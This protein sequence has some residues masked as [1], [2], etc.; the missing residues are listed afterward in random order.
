MTNL[1]SFRWLTIIVMALTLALPGEA[2]TPDLKGLWRSSSGAYLLISPVTRQNLK[3]EVFGADGS[4]V[5]TYKAS[6]SDSGDRFYYTAAG[7]DNI[8]SREISSQKIKVE[9]SLG[10]WSATWTRP[11]P[12]Q[13][14]ESF[15]H[16][17]NKYQSDRSL[18]LKRTGRLFFHPDLLRRIEE[19]NA[20]G[21][22]EGKWFDFDPFSNGQM[23]AAEIKLGP[24]NKHGGDKVRIPVE[25]SY[26]A[27]GH[28]VHAVNLELGR[29]G[30]AWRVTNLHYPGR[31][32]GQAWDLLTWM[33]AKPAGEIPAPVSEGG[34]EL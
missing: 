8:L 13:V 12:E 6:W 29:H 10:D 16:I 11:S 19:V 21:P 26:R 17:Y 7:G 20:R 30:G 33:G 1:P 32:G 15:Y 5:T 28:L 3:I 9:D 27:P 23:N 2:V 34:T 14:A 31:D 25:I 4:P 24:A 22:G 18:F